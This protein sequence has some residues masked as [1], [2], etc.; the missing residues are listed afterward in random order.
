M[1][2]DALYLY[3]SHGGLHLLKGIYLYL[4]QG[5]LHLLEG[6]YLHLSQGGLHLLEGIYLYLSQG[7]LHLL[8]GIESMVG[9]AQFTPLSIS[10]AS[11][12]SVNSEKP[13]LI[14]SVTDLKVK[15]KHLSILSFRLK[16]WS[17]FLETFVVLLS[18]LLY[19][20]GHSQFSKLLFKPLSDQ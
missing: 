9:S 20:A 8:E 18:N 10:L 12:I 5:G 3:L 14:L 13:N 16:S 6:I 7:G 17:L 4:S 19:K 1:I 11:S 2:W 15:D